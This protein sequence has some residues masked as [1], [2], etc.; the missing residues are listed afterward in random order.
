[1]CWWTADPGC[2]RRRSFGCCR[3][4]QPPSYSFGSCCCCCLFACQGWPVMRLLLS[5][6]AAHC[7]LAVWCHLTLAGWQSRAQHGRLCL[8][9]L[10]GLR[11]APDSSQQTAGRVA[12]AGAGWLVGVRRRRSTSRSVMQLRKCE[13]CTQPA[14]C[15]M[16]TV[17]YREM[18]GAA[19]LH[20][21]LLQLGSRH[22]RV[23]QL[24]GNKHLRARHIAKPQA[25]EQVIHRAC[26]CE[27]T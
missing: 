11:P 15:V 7:L 8:V 5:A 21:P 17:T 13:P 4:R 26:V 1:M 12:G 25:F 16:H 24:L 14:S 6:P 27:H 2:C 10:Q 20:Q 22:S 9:Q 19:L 23:Q 18:K 3:R